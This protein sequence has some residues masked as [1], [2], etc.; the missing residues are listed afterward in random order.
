MLVFPPESGGGGGEIRCL[1]W[2]VLTRAG[3]FCPLIGI[4]FNVNRSF[5]LHFPLK[6][7]D[8]SISS[9]RNVTFLV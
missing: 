5:R 9:F 6:L 1:F 3:G 4:I 2:K 7:D 8:L